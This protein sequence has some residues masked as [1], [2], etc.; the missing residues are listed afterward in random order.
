MHLW[1]CPCGLCKLPQVCIFQTSAPCLRLQWSGRQLREA[2]L[3][4]QDLAQAEAQR[5]ATRRCCLALALPPHVLHVLALGKLAVRQDG[6]AEGISL[7]TR[8]VVIS[9]AFLATDASHPARPL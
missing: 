4:Q 2:A 1:P 6:D 3:E 5:R 7:I 8:A 9:I